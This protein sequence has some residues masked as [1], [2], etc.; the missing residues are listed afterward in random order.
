MFNVN[1]AMQQAAKNKALIFM[2]GGG[3]FKKFSPGKVGI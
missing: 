2:F 3:I 1:K